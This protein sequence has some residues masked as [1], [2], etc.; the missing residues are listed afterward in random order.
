[1]AHAISCLLGGRTTADVPMLIWRVGTHNEEIG[2]S[3]QFAMPSA[4][5]KNDNITGVDFKLVSI[6]AADDQLG[7]SACKAEDFVRR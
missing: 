1:M 2:T 3:L 6:L 4:G 5:G 7:V